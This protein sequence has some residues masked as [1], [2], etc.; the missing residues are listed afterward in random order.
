MRFSGVRHD[1]RPWDKPDDKSQLRNRSEKDRAK[2][3]I[4]PSPR[5]ISGPK[6]RVSSTPSPMAHFTVRPSTSANCGRTQRDDCS[7]SAAWRIVPRPRGS[8]DDAI[9]GQRGLARRHL[10]MVPS[11]AA[12]R[13]TARYPGKGPS[14]VIVAPPKFAPFIRNVVSLYDV[15]AEAAGVAAP[16]D[17]VVHRRHLSA[18]CRVCRP[19]MGERHGPARSWSAEAGEFPRSQDHRKA[20]R[21]SAANADIRHKH[22]RPYPRARSTD[23]EAGIL[24]LHAAAL[25]R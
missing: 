13:S 7:S 12:S 25:R 9:C 14:W 11:A 17:P 18:F 20:Q 8:P 4:V 19:A 24:Q 23:F 22:L 15:M 2:L 5:T 6:S 21:Q 16:Q 3:D 10:A 1:M